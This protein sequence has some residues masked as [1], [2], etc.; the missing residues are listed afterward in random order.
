MKEV[1]VKAPFRE[2]DT[3]GGGAGGGGNVQDRIRT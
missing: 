3:E 1:A 2:V